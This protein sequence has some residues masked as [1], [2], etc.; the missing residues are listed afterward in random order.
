[1]KKQTVIYSIYGQI[2]ELVAQ[3]MIDAG[4]ANKIV[5]DDMP[6]SQ[7]YS[8]GPDGKDMQAKFAIVLPSQLVNAFERRCAALRA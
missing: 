3:A 2:E 1:M 8:R 4:T 6:M 7:R 5:F